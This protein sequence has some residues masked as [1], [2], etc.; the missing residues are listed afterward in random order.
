ME[1]VHQLEGLTLGQSGPTQAWCRARRAS[2]EAEA[3]LTQK[4][5]TAG[6]TGKVD[7]VGRRDNAELMQDLGRASAEV[8]EV[9]KFCCRIS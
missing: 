1:V 6:T 3:A 9:S 2:A 4:A 5:G 8:V 7:A